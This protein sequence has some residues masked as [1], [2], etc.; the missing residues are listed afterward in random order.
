MPGRPGAGALVARLQRQG[1]AQG[2]RL[3]FRRQLLLT[4][5][6]APV[7]EL[8]AAEIARAGAA[9]GLTSIFVRPDQQVGSI[10]I[11]QTCDI[12]ADPAVEPNCEAMPIIELADG[13]SLPRP[14]STRAFLLDAERRLIVDATHRLQFEKSL[15]P[16]QD[17][18]QLLVAPGQQRAFAA[19]LGRR[20]TR[21]AW[22]NDFEATVGNALRA[23]MAKKRF[24]DDPVS[25]HLHLI[26]VLLAGDGT[27]VHLV[28]PYDELQVGEDEA[29]TFAA[30]LLAQTSARLLKDTKRAREHATSDQEVRTFTIRALRPVRLDQLTMRAM[31]AAPPLNLEHLT[32][33]ASGISG[34]EPHVEA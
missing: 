10:L 2:C 24:A 32:Y 9:Q 12:V 3:P 33:T 27:D 20:A 4:D 29:A 13:V 18:E 14:N 5:A 17:A 28:L 26:R 23:T 31:I 7:S 30:D 34:V 15:I 8:A 1:W 22:P 25:D 21:A 16:D 11:T 6:A 19:W